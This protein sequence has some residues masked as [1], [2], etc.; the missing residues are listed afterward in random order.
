MK[1]IL[2]DEVNGDIFNKEFTTSEEA[3]TCAEREWN[4]LSEY[5][6]KK[7]TAFYVLESVNPDTEAMDH[8]DGDVIKS[9]K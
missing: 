7:R 8:F 4:S 2:M 3:L 6:K 1:Y 5:D 9:W